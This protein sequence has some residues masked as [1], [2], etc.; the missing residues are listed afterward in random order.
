MDVNDVMDVW[1][2]VSPELSDHPY[3][4]LTR[5]CSACW[6]LLKLLVN[7][8]ERLPSLLP[9]FDAGQKVKLKLRRSRV[10]SSL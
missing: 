7:V 6:M 10:M 5:A 3:D 9:A 1:V 2:R 4:S 8:L